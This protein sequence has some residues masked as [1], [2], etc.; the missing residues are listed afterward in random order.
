MKRKPTFFFI[1]YLTIISSFSSAQV[2]DIDGNVYQTVTIGT[3]VWMKE[4]LKTTKLND[5]I[6]LP[7]VIDNAAWAALTTTGYCW[8]NNDATTYKST[9][10]ALY[11]W[12]AVNTG[13]LC[14]I[15]WHV[16]SDDEWTLL[17]TFRGGYSV[18]GGKLKETGTLHWTS[19]NTGA[20][21]E[22]GFTALPGG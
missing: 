13:K 19:P 16:P 1:L 20:T 14:P 7:N 11:N 21:N 18:A 8:Y 5:G 12:Y 6:A 2:S 10:G 9:Y 4:N 3:Q 15:G 22:T 17:T